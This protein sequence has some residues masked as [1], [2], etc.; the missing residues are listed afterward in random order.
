[1]TW[2]SYNKLV[3][4]ARQTSFS[5]KA[6]LAK[7]GIHIIAELCYRKVDSG[8]LYSFKKLKNLY[9]LTQVHNKDIK[10]NNPRKTFCVKE[11]AKNTFTSFICLLSAHTYV[12]LKLPFKGALLRYNI[13]WI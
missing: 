9:R 11:Q 4:K 6:A 3:L 7:V 13:I 5:G 2:F 12:L 1:M 10:F 8:V